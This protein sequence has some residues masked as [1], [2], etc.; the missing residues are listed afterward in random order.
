MQKFVIQQKQL[1][2][3][4]I[5]IKTIEW[6]AIICS[7]LFTILAAYK[8]ILCWFF[9]IISVL[10]Y[11]YLSYIGNLYSEVILNVFYIFTTIYGWNTWRKKD[12]E[13]IISNISFEFHFK[14]IF[15]GLILTF[16]LG[17][18]FGKFTDAYK[19][20]ID[21]FTTSFAIIATFMMIKKISESWLY[22]VVIDAVSVYLYY[23]RGYE[24][25]AI[26]LYLIYTFLAIFA[27]Y[28]WKKQTKAI[29]KIDL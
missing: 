18:L 3:L 27:Y 25:S 21:S 9:S 8:S 10:L 20:F 17:F 14:W 16:S 28:N 5:S 12:S 11:L 23:F 24:N 29:E 2:N 4:E 13:N 7:W 22:F 15:L 6:I 1:F 19:P 26:F